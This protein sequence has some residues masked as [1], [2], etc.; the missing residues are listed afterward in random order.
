MPKLNKITTDQQKL[1]D[2]IIQNYLS[3][4]TDFPEFNEVEA[5]KVIEDLY[6]SMDQ[7]SPVIIV[8]NNPLETVYMALLN[9]GKKLTP[10]SHTIFKDRHPDELEDKLR[11]Q[12]N[13]QLDAQF[14]D[15]VFLEHAN[16][17]YERC[18]TQLDKQLRNKLYNQLCTQL[19]HHLVNQLHD[20]IHTRLL[21]K[22]S[23]Q[24]IDELNHH[25][26]NQLYIHL[27]TQLGNQIDDRLEDIAEIWDNT[28][29]SLRWRYWDCY[30]QFAKQLGIKLN[31]KKLD[32]FHRFLKYV[33]F[34][35]IPYEG[36]CFISKPPIKAY[37]KDARLHRDGGP[38]IEFHSSLDV[39]TFE[40]HAL[41]GV[42][43][44]KYLAETEAS[45]LDLEFFKQEK[46]AD[47][48][49]EFIRKYGIDRMLEMGTLVDSYENH[50]DS[51]NY[52]W[53]SSSK[54]KLY[55]MSS[56]FEI[57]SYL[58]YLYMENQTVK[59]VYHLECVFNPNDL[60]SQ[61]KTIIEGLTI[62][63]NGVNPESLIIENIA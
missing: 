5:K 43:V 19:N 7:A 41:N 58:P 46:N 13:A 44:S 48:K 53:Y 25:L 36:V 60:Y 47:V 10:E 56:L 8:G 61:P 35:V 54:Y 45:S 39:P 31:E 18:V 28:Y 42:S 24:L 62:R 32:L 30:F 63:M 27:R 38:S 34:V 16:E 51:H 37:Y 3:D 49:A 15:N 57:Y 20:Q 59:G 12:L 1:F 4:I 52:K 26:V 2:T 11:T 6:F 21:T 55:D 33:G 29:I 17:F 50:K 23:D 40:L 14:R 22:F 9:N